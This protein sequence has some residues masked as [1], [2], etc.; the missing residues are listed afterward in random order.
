MNT[1][2]INK[3]IMDISSPELQRNL[4][5]W[6]FQE[7]KIVFTNGC[8][9]I[10]H[11]G[12][13]KY[14]ADSADLG[15][16]FIIGLNSDASIKRIKGEMR[17]INDQISRSM[18]LASLFFVS[19]VVLFEEDTPYELIKHI[20]PDILVKGGDYTPENIVGFDI[21]KKKQGIVKTLDFIEGYST[22]AI[23]KKI[24]NSY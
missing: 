8:F 19:C 21:V 18:A 12:H 15:D 4:N 3:K 17:P 5:I 16:V 9:D 22:T 1:R 24:K 14:L 23:I 20:E 13:Y 6:R 10:L 2:L 7:K 11:Q